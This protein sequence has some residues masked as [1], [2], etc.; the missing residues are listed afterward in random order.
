[1]EEYGMLGWHISV[2]KQENDGRS[3]A[4]AMS[5]KG[6]RLAVWQTGFNGLDWLDELVKT[7]RAIDLGG[8]G[9]PSRYTA[10]AEYLIPR[11]IDKPPGAL[12]TWVAGGGDI[13]TNKWEGETVIDHAVAATCRPDEWLLVEVWDES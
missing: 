8:N 10:T 11:I 13:L 1:L 5:P 6:E 4:T 7:S 9:Y 3:P 2:Y 12:R